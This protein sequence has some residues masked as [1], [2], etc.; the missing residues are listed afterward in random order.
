M[1]R[2]TTLL[3]RS[4]L[5][6]LLLV[7]CAAAD[8]MI[9][10]VV[11]AS[12]V[13]VAGVDIDV[14]KLSGGGNP[15]LTNDGTDANGF[16][17]ATLDSGVYQVLFFPPPPPTTTLLTGVVNNVVV[18]G[19]A[20]LGVIT[21]ANGVSLSGRVV[22]AGSLPIA[23]VKATV[24]DQLSGA[25]LPLKNNTTGAFG[26]FSLAVPAHALYLDLD[27]IAVLGRTL[28]P[29][30]LDLAPAAN[31]NLG[32]LVLQSGFTLSGSV[33]NS[34]GAAL[35]NIDLDVSD[36]LSGVKLYTPRDTTDALGA[37][38]I[39]LPSGTYDV[40]VCPAFSRRLVAS[41]VA[42]LIFSA[43]LSVGLITLQNGVALTGT[44][45]TATG[46]GY[47]GADVNVR[48]ALSGLSVA[49][50]G[51]NTGAGG[52]YGVIV[53][54]GTLNIGF[55]LPGKHGT[56]GEDL[57][58]S[59]PIS[60]DTVLDGVLPA[61]AAE[62]SATPRTGPAPLSVTFSDLSSGAITAWAWDFSDFTGSTLASPTHVY[63][64]N[65][66]YTVALTLSGPGGPTTQSKLGYVVVSDAPPV[67]SFVG[68]PTSGAA[69]LAVNF[70]NQSTGP[71]TS[72][73]WSFG[74]GASS[75]L[76]SPSHTYTTPGTYTVSLTEFGSGTSD[77]L[78][79]VAY[80]VVNEPAPVA[81]FV[82]T[83]TSG[84]LPLLVSFTDQS[85]G[86]IT[87]HAWSFGDGGSS[88]LASP[89]HTYTLAGTY[90]VSLTE[91]GPGGA[92]TR[93]RTAY[94]VVS[95]AP[96]VAEF[97]ATPRRGR[98]LLPVVFQDQSTGVVTSWSWDFGDGTSSNARNPT[99]AYRA[100]GIFTVKLIVSGPGGSATEIKTG[101][102]VVRGPRR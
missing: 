70:T 66:T 41:S 43:N 26:T 52:A 59:V 90:T 50:C 16:F 1:N 69:P 24:F 73:A 60:G 62:F 9:G 18:V 94:I 76:A 68:A 57:H 3:F 33:R 64:A 67:A 44:V 61:P 47:V 86:A 28:V 10:R 8:T 80:I 93:T 48:N 36:S 55:A 101:Y 89:T 2:H 40:D 6:L 38:A 65:G 92:N 5:A 29:R 37:F 39:V 23:S 22:D 11:N 13:G 15:H 27:P 49:L 31:T 84:A 35:S 17:T 85:T 98:S 54:V 4:V 20:N 25:T 74:D 82:G 96:P 53:P 77:T 58:L 83:P 81:E 19:N 34:A 97:T 87:S 88:T 100:G 63:T 91:T 21:L 78:T 45:R 30:R 102:V 56:T 95:N 14:V 7:P 79:R 75:T 46:T 71:I 12:G 42:G 51:D 32:D 99:H 72:H